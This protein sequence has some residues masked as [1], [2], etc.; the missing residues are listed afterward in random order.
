[1]VEPDNTL[2]TFFYDER[3]V[4]VALERGAATPVRYYVATDQVGTP[5]R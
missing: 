2:W 3:G 1:M 4:L 5:A